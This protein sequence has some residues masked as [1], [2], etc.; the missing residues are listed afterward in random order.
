[1]KQALG[2]G[3]EFFAS[4]LFADDSEVDG[5]QPVYQDLK[6]FLGSTLLPYGF[7]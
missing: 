1:M 7:I 5:D 4:C 6:S 3:F 2:V